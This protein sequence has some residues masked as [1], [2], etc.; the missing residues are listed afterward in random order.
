M[1]RLLITGL[2]IFCL[3]ACADA[4]I[5]AE[6]PLAQS[7]VKLH[8]L[9]SISEISFEEVPADVIAGNDSEIRAEVSA[10]VL[11]IVRDAGSNVTR[12]ELLLELDPADLDLQLKQARAQAEAAEARRDQ[13]AQRLT[14]AQELRKR[15]FVSDDELTAKQTDLRNAEAEYEIQNASLQIARRNL[16]KTRIKAPFDAVIVER[17]AQVGSAVSPGTPLMRLVDNRAPEVEVHL[18]P[19]QT[20]RLQAARSIEFVSTDQVFP[21]HLLRVGAVVDQQSRTQVSRLGFKAEPAISGISGKLR[22]H[23]NAFRISP[24]WLVQRDGVFGV[25]VAQNNKAKFIAISGARADRSTEL[26]L[27]AETL[28]VTAGHRILEEGAELSAPENRAD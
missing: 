6:K 9:S 12:G 22:W 1:N 13:A 3:S 11:R 7:A 27:P 4:D 15:N 14:R 20:R 16:G 19:E 2:I 5:E 8:K 23:S 10:K 21:V 28:L 17:F 26:D 24:E 18:A 25:M